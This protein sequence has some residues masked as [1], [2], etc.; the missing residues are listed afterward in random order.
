[1]SKATTKTTETGKAT[2]VITNL[3]RFSYPHLFKPQKDDSGAEKYGVVLLVPKTDTK[4]VAAIKKAIEAALAEG[5]TSKFGGKKAG[6]KMPLR[7]GDEEKDDPAYKGMYFISANSKQRVP[8]ID[9]EMEPL[10]NEVDF[11]SGDWGRASITFFA[12][13]AEKSKGVGCGLNSV[14][15]LKDG[16]PLGYTSNPREDFA[17]QL[18]I[19][20]ELLE[21]YEGSE[22]SEDDDGE[23]W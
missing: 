1:M 19:D 3:V 6:L 10:V 22:G 14:Q 15:K 8:M 5:L 21:Q 13:N 17:E 9:A 2:K 11:K 16:K 12:Y 23:S 18:E 4:G 20:E 7:D